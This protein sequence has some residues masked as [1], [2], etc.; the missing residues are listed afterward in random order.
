LKIDILLCTNTFKENILKQDMPL[1]QKYD[2]VIPN[3]IKKIK[4]PEDQILALL[5]DVKS[6][7]A[8]L[9]MDIRR[10]SLQDVSNIIERGELIFPKIISDGN[11]EVKINYNVDLSKAK[12]LINDYKYK[13][14]G[15]CQSCIYIRGFM[16]LQDE[17]VT[18][19]SKYEQ[20]DA[21]DS[22]FSPRIDKFYKAGCEDK[23]S[24]IK[25]K[26]ENLLEGQA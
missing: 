2:Y 11:K 20:S 14:E 6:N 21:I 4:A 1:E 24:K 26:L 22:G 12:Q 10:L 19:C 18:F 8:L 15:G 5:R 23:E 9:N 3:H 16:P 17:H 13:S 7:V 25:R